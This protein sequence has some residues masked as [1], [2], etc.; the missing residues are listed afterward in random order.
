MTRSY[1][2][3]L[4]FIFI[5]VLVDV[6]GIGVIIP[7]MPDLITSLTDLEAN[8]AAP[9]GGWLIATYGIFQFLCAPILGELSDRFGR[10]PIILIALLGLGIDYIFHA[11]APTITWLFIGRII[12]GICGASF[13]AATSYIADISTPEKKAQNFGII[14]AG[15]GLGFIIGPAIGGFFGEM[16]IQ[17]PFFVAA[18]LTLLNLVYGY[19]FLPESLKPEHRRSVKWHRA[20]PGRSLLHLSKYTGIIGLI[21][22]FFLVNVAGFSVQSTWSFYTIFRFDWDSSE[23]GLSLALVGLIV[24]IIQGGLIKYIVKGLGE[25][26]T[27]LIGMF[28][29]FVGLLLFSY[30]SESWMMYAFIL[31]YCMGG[32]AS[33]TLQGLISNQVPLTEQGELQGA[34]AGLISISSIVS[35]IIMTNTFDYF[36]N[37][38]VAPFYMPGAAFVLGAIL[39][40]LSFFVVI[41]PLRNLTRKS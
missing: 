3:S 12:A 41:K 26:K 25:Y 31:P 20:I 27:I 14:G 35:P 34:I 21:F 8:E 9:W 36:S 40:F 39:V 18:G 4:G 37:A 38:E 2:A 13:S 6:I 29:W 1:K 22:T 7:V 17:I 28:F 33:P 5:T 23:I 19:F 11:F 24:A 16:G 15:F 10:R 32:I 30:A